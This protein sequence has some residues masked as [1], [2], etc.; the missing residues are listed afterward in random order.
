MIVHKKYKTLQII[1]YNLHS[2]SCG[3]FIRVWYIYFSFFNSAASSCL[4]IGNILLV[5]VT[6]IKY[7]RIAHALYSFSTQEL[8]K[9]QIPATCTSFLPRQS[10]YETDRTLYGGQ[11]MKL[12]SYTIKKKVLRADFFLFLNFIMID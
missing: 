4:R 3:R 10:L 8:C 7:L 11:I 12:D 6:L 2:W 9:G 5:I 1:N